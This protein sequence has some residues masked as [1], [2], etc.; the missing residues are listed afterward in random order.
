VGFQQSVIAAHLG[1][2]S[3]KPARPLITG[4]VPVRLIY[5]VL[6]RL[7]QWLTLLPRSDAAKD[8][9]ILILRHQNAILQRAN[10]SHAWI[11][12]T[13]PSSPPWP[14]TFPRR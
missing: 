9:E 13:G 12:P 4:I 5:L 11:G 8:V 2:Y 14:G 3:A 6:C 7:A 1:G 10:S